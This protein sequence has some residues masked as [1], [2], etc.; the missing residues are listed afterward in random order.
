M[1]KLDRFGAKYIRVPCFQNMGSCTYNDICP[2]LQ[3]FTC[4]A[5]DASNLNCHCPFKKVNLSFKILLYLF[6]NYGLKFIYSILRG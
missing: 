3:Q 1:E 5:N 6:F 4:D 2:M